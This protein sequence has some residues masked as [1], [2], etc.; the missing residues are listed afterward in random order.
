MECVKASKTFRLSSSRPGSFLSVL[1]N[2]RSLILSDSFL[3][4][5]TNDAVSSVAHH[6]VNLVNSWVITNSALLD[7]C[8][9]RS[10]LSWAMSERSSMLNRWMF[11]NS[12]RTGST[13]RGIA[14]SKMNKSSVL[15]LKTESMTLCPIMKSRASVAEIKM[16]HDRKYDPIS[17]NSIA[18]PSSILANSSAFP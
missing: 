17:E 15:S 18:T 3:R 9:R 16:L 10:K 12:D 7:D 1:S 14:K 2:S 11:F 8:F 5:W 13:S 4:A 6:S